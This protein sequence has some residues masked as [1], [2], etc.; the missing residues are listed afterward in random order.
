MPSKSPFNSVRVKIEHAG[1]T[2]DLPLMRVSLHDRK[3]HRVVNPHRQDTASF[4]GVPDG[5][6]EVVISV[7]GIVVGRVAINVPKIGD[8]AITV[9][10]ERPRSKIWTVNSVALRSTKEEALKLIEAITPLL[11]KHSPFFPKVDAKNFIE[12]LTVRVV[13]PEQLHQGD[14]TNFCWAAAS[15]SYMIENDPRGYVG[16][17]FGLY[18]NGKGVYEHG[19]ERLQLEPSASVRESV[20]SEVFDDNAGLTGQIVDQM[21]LM[22]L[23]DT[24]KGWINRVNRAYDEGDEEKFTWAGGDFSKFCRVMRA[25]DYTIQASGYDL[26]KRYTDKGR[27]IIEEQAAGHDV[28]LFVHSPTFKKKRWGWMWNELGTHYV[29][30]TNFREL[31]EEYVMDF[32][33]YG[34]WHREHRL[35]Q[36]RFEMCTYGVVIIKK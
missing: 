9:K 32:W 36:F 21:L 29:R 24:F 3:V 7:L 5:D 11:P 28:I 15:M 13:H 25:F 27:R 1:D 4:H 26:L 20:G 34:E 19:A 8:K 12:Q 10:V 22:T 30:V 2:V 16:L 17:M 23:A 18:V 14:G 6:T 31:G 35:E 33:D